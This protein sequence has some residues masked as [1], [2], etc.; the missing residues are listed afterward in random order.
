[1]E[2]TTTWKIW[3]EQRQSQMK[4]SQPIQGYL[5]LNL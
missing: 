1:M 3:T 2:K 5:E 4:S